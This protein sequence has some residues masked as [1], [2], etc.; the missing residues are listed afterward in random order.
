M[1]HPIMHPEAKPPVFARHDHPKFAEQETST[2]SSYEGLGRRSS[3]DGPRSRLSLVR[4]ASSSGLLVVLIHGDSGCASQWAEVQSCLAPHRPTLALDLR[5]HGASGPA[6]DGDYS[7]AGRADDVVAAADACGLGRFLLVAHSGGA[8]VALAVGAACPGRVAGLLMID[9]ATDPAVLPREVR[10]R[11]LADLTGPHGLDALKAYY[12]SIAG[13][14]PSLRDRVL[15]DAEAVH[16]D[17]RL[18]TA[19]ALAAWD[20]KAALAAAPVPIRIV[21]TGITDGPA[22]LWRLPG[23]LP[24]DLPTEVIPGTGHWLQ[25]ERPDLVSERVEDFAAEM[26]SAAPGP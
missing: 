3:L 19:R 5:G 23:D 21:A 1:T 12:A 6:S 20:P 16:P 24:L 13:T 25:I 7:Y 10:D 4:T 14:D 17:A 22:A 2:E 18:G 11:F 15:R 8:G 9:P 26:E